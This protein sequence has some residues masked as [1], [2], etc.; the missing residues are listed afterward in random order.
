VKKGLDRLYR[1]KERLEK[2]AK[3]CNGK[4]ID[5]NRLD[6]EEKKFYLIM[7]NFK[8]NFEKAMDDDFNTPKAFAA[9]FDFVSSSNK[10]LEK[11]DSVDPIIFRYSLDLFLQ[12][13]GVLTL[14]QP[15][16]DLHDYILMEKLES[17][18]SKYKISID[19]KVSDDLV[20]ILLNIRKKAREQK[21]WKKADE[22][23]NE[24]E[25]IGYEI[26]DT[27]KGPIWRRK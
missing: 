19:T 12:L 1:F 8:I 14:F 15:K 13:G 20:K 24:L 9:I 27:E 17:L 3:N 4:I 6:E 25:E 7:N 16:T 18:L 23:R 22:I 26:Q 10:F 21:N 11:N 2:L 5:T